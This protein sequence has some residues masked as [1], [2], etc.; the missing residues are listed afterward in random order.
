MSCLLAQGVCTLEV[1]PQFVAPVVSFCLVEPHVGQWEDKS[2]SAIWL[3]APLTS[4]PTLPQ[5]SIPKL[6]SSSV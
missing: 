1:N 5:R 3:S 6:S 4:S 2:V